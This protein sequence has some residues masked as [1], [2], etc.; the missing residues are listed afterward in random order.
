[1]SYTEHSADVDRREERKSVEGRLAIV[2]V[3]TTRT[4]VECGGCHARAR[5]QDTLEHSDGC[6]EQ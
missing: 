2:R 1:M 6:P 3:T 5:S 4:W